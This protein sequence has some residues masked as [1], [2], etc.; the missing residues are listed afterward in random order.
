MGKNVLKLI[1]RSKNTIRNL[2]DGLI[3]YLKASTS[4]NLLERFSKKWILITLILLF[5]NKRKQV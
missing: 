2:G 1:V 4:F 3:I 5:S